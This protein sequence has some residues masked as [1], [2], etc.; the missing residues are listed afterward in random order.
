MH[1]PWLQIKKKINRPTKILMNRWLTEAELTKTAVLPHYSSDVKKKNVPL[2]QI[3]KSQKHL[4]GHCSWGRSWGARSCEAAQ[5]RVRGSD[6]VVCQYRSIIYQEGLHEPSSNWPVLNPSPNI[7]LNV[8]SSYTQYVFS[9]EAI[10]IY[11][12][13]ICPHQYWVRWYYSTGL[14]QC[15]TPY[16][17]A[18]LYAELRILVS[19]SFQKGLYWLR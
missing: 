8:S 16:S 7:V 18:C 2:L 12:L 17:W 10:L 4:C 3:G 14:V 13:R 1:G 5:G 15:L 9:F 6:N 19:H 11:T